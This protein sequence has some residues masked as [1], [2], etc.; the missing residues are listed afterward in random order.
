MEKLK[1]DQNEYMCLAER[2]TFPFSHA[3]LDSAINHRQSASCQSILTPSFT[4]FRF[5]LREQSQQA[6]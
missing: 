6:H 5:T 1:L 3:K 4:L 2:I